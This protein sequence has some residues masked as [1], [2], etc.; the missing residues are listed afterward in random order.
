MTFNVVSLVNDFLKTSA[1]SFKLGLSTLYNFIFQLFLREVGIIEKLSIEVLE[2]CGRIVPIWQNFILK[3]LKMLEKQLSQAILVKDAKFKEIVN[4]VIIAISKSIPKESRMCVFL[5]DGFSIIEH[6]VTMYY[7]IQNDYSASMLRIIAINPIGKTQY[8]IKSQEVETLRMFCKYVVDRLNQLNF[9]AEY[10]LRRDLDEF[11]HT[12]KEL[13]INEVIHN[14]Q[15][16]LKNII[17]EI[18]HYVRRGY[19]VLI[20]SDHGY[21]IVKSIQGLRLMHG[22]STDKVVKYG[23]VLA[24]S[25]FIFYTILHK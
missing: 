17:E 4:D 24:L 21:D 16:I 9:N 2:S 22:L 12:E 13:E 8:F 7:V 23:E 6:I 5:V 3:L 18:E 11:I 15:Y 14:L 20:T 25:P 19:Y 1:K 10:H